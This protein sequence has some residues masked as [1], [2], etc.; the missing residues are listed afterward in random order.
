[1]IYLDT[2]VAAW[3]YSGETSLLSERA[4]DAIEGNDDIL[5]SP[6]VLL[7]L[8]YLR[9]IRR[10]KPPPHEILLYLSREINLHLCE[11]PFPQ[12]IQRALDETWT[13]D[14]FDRII[15]AQAGLSKASLVTADRNTRRHYAASVW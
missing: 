15:V 1:M 14:P 5:I 3:L 7:E 8:E 9:E 10:I 12:V 13:R 11:L 2:H 4:R 6:M